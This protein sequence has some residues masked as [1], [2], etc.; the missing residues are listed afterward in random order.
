MQMYFTA[1]LLP[2]E[3]NSEIVKLKKWAQEGW[4]CKVGLKSPAHITLLP[5]FWMD[6]SLEPAFI[7]ELN[8]LYHPLSPFP[9][10]TNNFSA[11]K[12]RTIFI[13]VVVDEPLRSLKQQTDLYFKQRPQYGAKIDTRPFHPHITIATRDLHKSAFA[14]AWPQVENKVFIETFPAVG[15]SVLRHNGQ[16]WDVIHTS[17]FKA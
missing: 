3:L 13:D 11:F 17:L 5:P 4:G 1:V 2:P 9:I 12:P 10:A 6:Q 15:T 14:E 16:R 7:N 8:A